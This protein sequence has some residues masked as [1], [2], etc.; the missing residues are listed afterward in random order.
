MLCV[1]ASILLWVLVPP[2]LA[3]RINVRWAANISAESRSQLE[4]EF[5]LVAGRLVADSVWLY[6]LADVSTAN[7][8]ALISH[9]AVADTHHLDRAAGVV[10]EDADLGTTP[11]PPRGLAALRSSLVAK[12]ITFLAWAS[13]LV[14]G[15][16]LSTRTPPRR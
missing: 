6:E 1:I 12:G 8:K 11:V 9:P 13:L 2:P 14:S 3:P 10:A 15:T 4:Q 7:I 5:S 16:W